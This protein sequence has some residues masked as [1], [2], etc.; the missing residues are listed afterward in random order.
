VRRSASIVGVSIV[1]LTLAWWLSPV[2]GGVL[3]I[4]ASV[5]LAGALT[6]GRTDIGPRGPHRDVPN[7]AGWYL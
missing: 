5:V 1:V 3:T 6:P 2:L 7:D 4:V